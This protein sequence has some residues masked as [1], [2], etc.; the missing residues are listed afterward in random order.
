M[1]GGFNDNVIEISHKTFFQNIRDSKCDFIY[2]SK[3]LHPYY[4]IQSVSTRMLLVF[5]FDSKQIPVYKIETSIQLCEPKLI[6]FNYR[7]A[8]TPLPNINDTTVYVNIA[9]NQ[10]F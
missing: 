2:Q 8:P 10:S 4:N 1:N 3:E 6:N 7:T 9:D 5:T